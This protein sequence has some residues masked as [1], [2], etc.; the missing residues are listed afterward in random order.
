MV[1]PSALCYFVAGMN[2]Q[3]ETHGHF[4]VLPESKVMAQSQ[5]EKIL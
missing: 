2:T 3:E 5:G 4:C 1:L